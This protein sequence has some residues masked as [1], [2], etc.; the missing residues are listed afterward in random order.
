VTE[1]RAADPILDWSAYRDAGLG[2]AYADIPKAGGHFARA[3]SVCINSRQCE[4]DG[5][6]VMCPSYRVSHRQLLSP[7]GRVRL[8]KAALNADAPAQALSEP[9]I[10]D[11][12]EAC[13][14][15]KGCKRECENSLDMAMIKIEYLAQQHRRHKPRLRVRLLGNLS[16]QLHRYRS[17]WRLAEWRNRLPWLARLG[18]QTLGISRS[19]RVPVPQRATA[20]QRL[21]AAA[22]PQPAAEPKDEVVLLIDTFTNNFAPENAEAARSVLQ[23]AGYRVHIATGPAEERPLCCGR[24]QLANGLVDQAREEARRML[25]ALLPHVDA[26]RRVIGLEPAC[27]LAIRDDYLFLGLGEAARKVASQ[28]LLFEEFIA[29]EMTAK[30]FQLEL[31]PVNTGEQPLLVHGH[32]HQK[33]VGAMKAMRKVL[34]AIPTLR[35][36]LIEASCCGMAGSFG[37]EKEHADQGMQMA[38]LSLLPALRE[39]PQ[40]RVLT[41]G[42][43]CRHQ[44][45]EGTQRHA[46]HLASLLLE[47]SG[48][49][50]HPSRLQEAIR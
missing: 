50:G 19:R 18:E 2:D 42:F 29:R 11:A 39:R 33:A 3:V 16:Q 44:I 21:D 27:L 34:K 4:S 6:G 38:E 26:G 17:A 20:L 23:R 30:R 24:T 45:H 9:E 14:G 48:S 43:S 22:E 49:A 46:I 25:D 41:N 15:C 37:I 1:K 36:E 8:L 10:A 28:A 12:M 31:W 7:G 47:A 5:K 13:V 32:C 35:F 40:A